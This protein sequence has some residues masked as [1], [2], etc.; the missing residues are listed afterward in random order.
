M[1]VTN[2]LNIKNFILEDKSKSN[3]ENRTFSEK[4]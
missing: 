4:F 1:S 2:N 3:E